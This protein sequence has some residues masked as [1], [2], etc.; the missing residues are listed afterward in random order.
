MHPP[1]SLFRKRT[2]YLYYSPKIRI[3]AKKLTGIRISCLTPFSINP[4]K[5]LNLCLLPVWLRLISEK[6][7]NSYRSCSSVIF[8]YSP[9]DAQLL[10]PPRQLLRVIYFLSSHQNEFLSGRCS[11]SCFQKHVFTAKLTIDKI[12]SPKF[13]RSNDG[14]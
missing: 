9:E 13:G 8:L 4:V 2:P 5:T 3:L 7:S 11:G 6:G 14:I 12:R 10:Y 1:K